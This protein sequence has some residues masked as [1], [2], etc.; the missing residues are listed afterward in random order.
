MISVSEPTNTVF[1]KRLICFFVKTQLNVVTQWLLSMKLLWIWGIPGSISS[2]RCSYWALNIKNTT[3][4]PHHL[5]LLIVNT[6][7]AVSHTSLVLLSGAFPPWFPSKVVY[8][9]VSPFLHPDRFHNFV[10]KSILWKH[11]KWS[12]FFYN[13]IQHPLT[14]FLHSSVLTSSF[15]STSNSSS[16]S[17]RVWGRDSHSY[18]TEERSV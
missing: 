12:P 3:F 13:F 9:H 7:T 15:S 16:S 11:K 17:F 1:R 4:L 18:K 6:L 8:S 5:R 10:N 2:H 14:F